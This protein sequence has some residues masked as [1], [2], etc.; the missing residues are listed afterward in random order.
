MD[1]QQTTTGTYSQ[2]EVAWTSLTLSNSTTSICISPSNFSEQTL[3]DSGTSLSIIPTDMYNSL[4]EYFGAYVD[5]TTGLQLVNCD[6][7]QGSL[8]FGFGGSSSPL[9]SVPFSELAFPAYYQ[10]TST[11]Q[12][13]ML[14]D[15]TQACSFGLLPAEGLGFYVL[16]DTFL[17]SAYVVFD[18]DD[19]VIGIAQS[20]FNSTSSNV[21]EI[22]AGNQPFGTA[23]A[24][25]TGTEIG[26]TSTGDELPVNDRNATSAVIAST[27]LRSH[28][29]VTSEV[30]ASLSRSTYE[31][32]RSA[33][34]S[35]ASSTPSSGASVP[36]AAGHLLVSTLGA[37]AAAAAHAVGFWNLVD[38]VV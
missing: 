35:S 1:N 5:N 24:S 4:A 19:H 10:N 14:S 3:L 16:G 23:V 12:P 20:N 26:R 30:T 31:T 17:R 36:K 7:G 18:L 8:D 33:T 2:F 38:R 34:V 9:V 21:V 6:L 28:T 22:H 25:A 37:A 29:A 27:S 11:P 15:G 13:V 32:I